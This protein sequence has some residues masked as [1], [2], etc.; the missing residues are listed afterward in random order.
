M[1][2]LRALAAWW[3]DANW[4]LGKGFGRAAPTAWAV[5]PPEGSCKSNSERYFCFSLTFIQ[6]KIFRLFLL[7]KPGANVGLLCQR[8]GVK[9]TLEEREIPLCAH[10]ISTSR[11]RCGV[12]TEA[13]QPCLTMSK[14]CLCVVV[15]WYGGRWQ[16]VGVRGAKSHCLLLPA[17][18]ESIL[19]LSEACQ[20]SQKCLE[21][22]MDIVK[23]ES[24]LLLCTS[25]EVSV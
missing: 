13:P 20:T 19:K 15:S 14:P 3:W 21:S 25:L 17:S 2:G 9:W 12:K 22:A 5:L 7:A 16:E 1:L 24:W 23:Q 6:A 10:E 18:T 4:F 8:S 11:Y